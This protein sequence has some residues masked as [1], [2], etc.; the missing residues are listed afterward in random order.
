[1]TIDARL[2]RNRKI[3]NRGLRVW[4]NGV[5]VTRR[6]FYADGRRGVVRLYKLNANG[7]KYREPIANYVPWTPPDVVRWRVA[8]EEL[9]GKVRWGMGLK[10][11]A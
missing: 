4:F 1:M 10:V 9:R 8:T 5:E 7:Q 6:C 3:L 11:A 2:R